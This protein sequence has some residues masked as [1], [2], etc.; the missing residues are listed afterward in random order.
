MGRQVRRDDEGSRYEIVVDGDVAG[1]AEFTTLDGATALTHTVVDDAY[2]GRGVGGEL[3]AGALDDLRAGGTK[4]VP[5]C[6]FV[7]R[8]IERHEDY[9]DLVDTEAL[10]R[11]RG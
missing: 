4:V 3:V 8:W 6:P 2:E 1:F 9:A 5:L 10:A 11:Y 7:A